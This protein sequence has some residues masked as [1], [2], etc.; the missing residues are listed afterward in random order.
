[1]CDLIRKWAATASG[2]HCAETG[3]A[4]R[5]GGRARAGSIENRGLFWTLVSTRDTDKSGRAPALPLAPEEEE[6]DI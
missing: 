5:E 1:M 6:E 4:G 3:L 2:Q